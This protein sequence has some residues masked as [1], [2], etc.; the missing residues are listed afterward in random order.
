MSAEAEE[1][2]G[3]GGSAAA[4]SAAAASAAVEAPVAAASPPP[5]AV[6][7][8]ST[9]AV[10]G[11]PGALDNG[12]ERR[13]RGQQERVQAPDAEPQPGPGCAA[14]TPSAGHPIATAS[15]ALSPPCLASR[16]APS[17]G[18]SSSGGGGGSGGGGDPAGGDARGRRSV[19]TP[20][21]ALRTRSRGR[22]RGVGLAG[23]RYSGQKG[24]NPQRGDT[25]QG[26]P[27][28]ARGGGGGGG[29]GVGDE[30]RAQAAMGINS[31]PRAR[32]PDVPASPPP[33][34][35]PS[36]ETSLQG[37][38]SLPESQDV[39]GSGSGND[40]TV[41]WDSSG[42]AAPRTKAKNNGKGRRKTLLVVGGGGGGVAGR[43][44]GSSSRR[45][46]ATAAKR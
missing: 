7:S 23:P 34:P 24:G 25:R 9:R 21:L 30:R 19:V 40:A 32:T 42:R 33:P 18:G 22:R 31:P 37:G 8:A 11:S 17:D 35:L 39:R 14:G 12:G 6:P 38:S 45:A 16:G 27:A 20:P 5:S 46:G 43:L 41:G 3:I 44:A 15:A 26:T 10:R 29:A 1:G 28:G 36:A 13:Q 4:A 2:E